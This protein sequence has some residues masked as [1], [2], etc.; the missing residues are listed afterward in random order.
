MDEVDLVDGVDVNAA[1]SKMQNGAGLG[2]RIQEGA[3]EIG[4]A[5]QVSDLDEFVAGMGLFDATG[6]DGDARS[7]LFGKKRGI[8]K[9]RDS[10]ALGTKGHEFFDDR[11]SR[12]GV[13]GT[14]DL[15][16]SGL[17]VGEALGEK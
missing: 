4:A 6:A 7:V 10:D 2:E 11:V 12:V 15:Y 5:F 1:N 13:K 16:G 17:D 3:E 8:A 14:R 9:P